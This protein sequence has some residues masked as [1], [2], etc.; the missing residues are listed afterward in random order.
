MWHNSNLFNLLKKVTS[1]GRAT[2]SYSAVQPLFNINFPWSLD[3]I[4][5]LAFGSSWGNYFTPGF[6]CSQH[7][8]PRNTQLVQAQPSQGTNSHLLS[9]G[10]SEIHFFCP[11]K[12][13]LGHGRIRTTDL[14]ICS[15]TRYHWTSAP[16][17]T[18]EAY[19]QHRQC[20]KVDMSTNKNFYINISDIDYKNINV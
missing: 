14:S 13:T 6:V 9:N 3:Y 20:V 2:F 15:W 19:L 5:K 11:V 4:R 8:A 16:R 7:T 12:F 10:A 18:N 1:F 17:Y